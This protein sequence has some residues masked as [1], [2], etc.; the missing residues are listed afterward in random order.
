MT[1]KLSTGL[2]NALIPFAARPGYLHVF[3]GGRPPSVDSPPTG[4]LL[5][6]PIPLVRGTAANG[7]ISLVSAGVTNATT[8]GVAGWARVVA[9]FTEDESATIGAASLYD[10]T[11]GTSGSGADLIL[12]T[13]SVT[14]GAPITVS[15][16]ITQTA[17]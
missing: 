11:I 10:L 2:R 9:E 12:P 17:E 8:A 4:T 1:I 15:L 6:P 7:T 14:V 3:T 13:T 5:C 16:N